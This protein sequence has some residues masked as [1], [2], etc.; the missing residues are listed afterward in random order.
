MHERRMHSEKRRLAWQELPIPFAGRFDRID[1]RLGRYLELLHSGFMFFDRS[2]VRVLSHHDD[3]FRNHTE[4][5]SHFLCLRKYMRS[6]CKDRRR[7]VVGCDVS[8]LM[9]VLRQGFAWSL[10]GLAIGLVGAVAS[11]RLV[12]HMLYG[13]Q[14]IDPVTYVAVVVGL[15]AVVAVA[16][17]VPSLR[18]TRVDPL[19]S[20]RAR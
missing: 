12:S 13:I 18:A 3:R 11:G 16:C 4:R 20:M 9:L 19:T 10:A 2:A 15:A 1:Q 6:R 14:P 17:L 5:R 7:C 8:V